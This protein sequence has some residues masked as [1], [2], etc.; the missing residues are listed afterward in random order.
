MSEA[1]AP[2]MTPTFGEALRFWWRLGWISFGGPTGQIA[3]MHEE[4]V[5][6]KRWVEEAT[7]LHALNFCMMLPGPE[8]Q[9]L[10]TYLGWRLHGTRG[11]LCAGLLFILPAVF[12]L[13]ALSLIYVLYG[14]VPFVA[15]AFYGLV[16][17]VIAIVVRALCRLGSRTLKQPLSIFIAVAAALAIGVFR[18][19]YPLVVLGAGLLGW[20][21]R[22]AAQPAPMPP[23]GA[24]AAPIRFFNL[25]RTGSI[26]LVA[27][28]APLVLSLAILGSAST[29]SR[30]GIF[31]SKAALLGFGGAYALLPYVAQHAVTHLHWLDANDMLHG[32]ALAETTP[33]PLIMVLQF[34]GFV[35]AWHQPGAL[36]PLTAATL[37]SL[38][39]TWVVF[40]PSFFFILVGA[41]FVQR[42][43]RIAGLQSALQA[44]SAAVVGVMANFALWFGG[45]ALFPNHR[46]AQPDLFVL[47]VGAGALIAFYRTRIG[48]IPVLAICSAL[49][50][51]DRLL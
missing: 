1:E 21:F 37:G 17:A 41:P 47:V 42:L 31:F 25:L 34:V 24:D 23:T 5:D 8:A 14:S 46:I 2:P 49:G 3:I 18:G 39:T 4:V 22:H 13:W 10:A 29:I 36:S 20:C 40:A 45:H 35:G 7:F 12:I 15:A 11:A 19:S 6:R 27:W 9:Q 16:P 33:G 43:T 30:E 32:L 28:W 26:C 38:L 44:I 50:V 51:L 48:V